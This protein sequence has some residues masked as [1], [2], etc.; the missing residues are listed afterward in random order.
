MWTRQTKFSINMYNR[1]KV[2]MNAFSNRLWY[3]YGK[4]NTGWFNYSFDTYKVNCKRL[5]LQKSIRELKEANVTILLSKFSLSITGFSKQFIEIHWD[6]LRLLDCWSCSWQNSTSNQKLHT[7]HWVA[8]RPFN[9]PLMY[10][11]VLW[12]NFL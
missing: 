8:G 4:I 7:K 1:K 3:L 12:N 6:L 2:G 10:I 5:L 9:I 11:L